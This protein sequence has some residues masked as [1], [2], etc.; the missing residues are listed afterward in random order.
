M[1]TRAGLSTSRRQSGNGARSAG[2]DADGA[3]R[4][5]AARRGPRDP[6][7]RSG[8]AFAGMTCRSW[9]PPVWRRSSRGVA[10]CM[11]A[12]GVALGC[13]ASVAS[14]V[15]GAARQLSLPSGAAVSGQDAALESVACPRE[16]DCLAVGSYSERGGLTSRW[17]SPLRPVWGARRSYRSVRRRCGPPAPSRPCSSP[18]PARRSGLC[19]SRLLHRRARQRANRWC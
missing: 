4:G 18:S 10:V 9:R 11:A 7:S 1:T 15:R 3:R 6:A 13:S 14:P 19:R 12:A 17:R 5:G 2:G 16:R 8:V